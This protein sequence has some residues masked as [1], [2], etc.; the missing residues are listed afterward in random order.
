MLG[1]KSDLLLYT[2]FTPTN[3][4]FLRQ[5]YYFLPRNV[6]LCNTFICHVAA[7]HQKFCTAAAL[8]QIAVSVQVITH[9]THALQSLFTTLILTIFCVIKF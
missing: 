9:V 5:I 6:I 8:R 4:D 7:T 2:D 1:H 3:L